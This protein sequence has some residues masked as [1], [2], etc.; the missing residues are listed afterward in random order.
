MQ[1]H[2]LISSFILLLSESVGIYFANDLLKADTSDLRRKL[3]VFP[4]FRLACAMAA[5]KTRQNFHDVYKM[6]LAKHSI[7]KW[8]L[9]AETWWQ[10]TAL[11]SWIN[12]EVR[13]S[14]FLSTW[15]ASF[16]EN[17]CGIIA[18]DQLLISNKND[19]LSKLHSV[20][21]FGTNSLFLEGMFHSWI[22]RAREKSV[23]KQNLLFDSIKTGLS[24]CPEVNK[25]ITT[26]QYASTHA[27]MLVTQ[28]QSFP[29]YIISN[30]FCIKIPISCIEFLFMRSENITTDKQLSRLDVY[31]VASRYKR[32]L[33]VNNRKVSFLEANQIVSQWKDHA[34][35]CLGK[36]SKMKIDAAQ[37]STRIDKSPQ[38]L[39]VMYTVNHLSS[40]TIN[41]GM[42]TKTIY[43]FDDANDSLY[44]FRVNIDKSR[45]SEN[46]GNGAFLTFEGCKVLKISS[47]WK[48]KNLSGKQILLS[49]S[50][51][52]F[53][54]FHTQ[55]PILK[56]SLMYH[57]QGRHSQL[58]SLEGL[59]LL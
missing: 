36:K 7:K 48:K 44:K 30:S 28:D 33:E 26:S 56:T 15:E 4:G 43:T 40:I 11:S 22:M 54:V 1:F 25:N 9:I 21:N 2:D 35:N 46:G 20:N 8:K 50:I 14:N 17:N 6:S 34:L 3:I 10:K 52:H 39:S 57:R 23:N 29:K 59:E 45:V 55:F 24:N 41:D 58:L 12:I 31:N 37:F 19:I 27:N 51:F 13:L 49:K 16:L 32:F 53:L 47:L 5:W 18:V 42:P 38:N